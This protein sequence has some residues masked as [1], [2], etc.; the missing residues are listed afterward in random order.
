MI[1]VNGQTDYSIAA[2]ALKLN[3]AP[4]SEAAARAAQSSKSPES[5]VERAQNLS[6]QYIPENG[7]GVIQTRVAPEHSF[8]KAKLEGSR[9]NIEDMAD[10]LMN[11]LPDILKDMKRLTDGTEGAANSRV[12]VT[13]RNAAAVAER[14]A[15]QANE[16]MMNFSL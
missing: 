10:K 7:G 2:Q 13:E 8:Q 9:S 4:R 6:A 11:K 1:R 12:V 16:P 15:Q 14:N 3:D 5:I